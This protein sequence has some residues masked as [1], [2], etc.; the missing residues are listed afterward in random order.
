[1]TKKFKIDSNFF[2]NISNLIRV[3]QK[4]IKPVCTDFSNFHKNQPILSSFS[5]NGCNSFPIC[6]PG[7]PLAAAAAAPDH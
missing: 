7:C 1:L 6:L 4:S 5:I 2:K 3:Y